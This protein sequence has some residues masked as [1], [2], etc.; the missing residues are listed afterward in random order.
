MVIFL[1]VNYILENLHDYL[2]QLDFH[3][4]KVFFDNKLINL[5]DINDINVKSVKFEKFVG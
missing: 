3:R 1:R 4:K 5:I 2:Q